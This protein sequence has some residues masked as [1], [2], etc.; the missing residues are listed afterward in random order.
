[1][2]TSAKPIVTCAQCGR[3]LPTDSVERVRWRPSEIVTAGELDEMTA[4]A[5]LCPDCASHD[6]LDEHELGEVD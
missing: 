2:E 3:E 5:L 1:M 6:L 4:G